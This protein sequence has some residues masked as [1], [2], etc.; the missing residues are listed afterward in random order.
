MKQIHNLRRIIS[1]RINNFDVI[2]V[3]RSERYYGN[4]QKKIFG[5]FR[6]GKKRGLAG[7]CEGKIDERMRRL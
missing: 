6:E 3:N 1:C 4:D 7:G 5:S 2:R